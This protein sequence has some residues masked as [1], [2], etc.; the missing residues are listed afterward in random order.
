MYSND[1][2]ISKNSVQRSF[3]SLKSTVLK[4]VLRKSR[5]LEIKLL[6][7]NILSN[8]HIKQIK[9]LTILP[10]KFKIFPTKS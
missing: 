10:V 8:D 5:K 7:H 1:R 3:E 4:K 9:C 6:K 2:N